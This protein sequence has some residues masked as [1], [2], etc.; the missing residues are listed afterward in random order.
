M[1][2]CFSTES[3]TE[4]SPSSVGPST[5]T[6]AQLVN[7]VGPPHSATSPLAPTKRHRRKTSKGSV[8]TR[9]TSRGSDFSSTVAGAWSSHVAV[10]SVPSFVSSQRRISHENPFEP[11]HGMDEL[12]NAAHQRNSWQLMSSTIQNSLE[13]DQL[14]H[15]LLI[16]P[17]NKAPFPACEGS[18]GESSAS[19]VAIVNHESEIH[20]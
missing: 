15:S 13:N 4:S 17:S 18:A 20:F 12:K 19:D 11:P 1:G 6:A 8:S 10:P 9:R 3:T 5:P 7:D 16:P 14:Q 2:E